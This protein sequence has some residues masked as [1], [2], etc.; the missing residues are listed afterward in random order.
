MFGQLQIMYSNA[1]CRITKHLK[2]NRNQE[3]Y[4]DFYTYIYDQS[5]ACYKL[6]RPRLPSGLFVCFMVYLNCINA[7]LL[8]KLQ[9]CTQSLSISSLSMIANNNYYYN[10]NFFT[11]IYYYHIIKFIFQKTNLMN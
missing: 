6:L 8:Y 7:G 10:L 4:K 1:T 11:L 9:Y 5:I 2:L 3:Q